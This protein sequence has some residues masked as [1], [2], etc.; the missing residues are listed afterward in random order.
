[1]PYGEPELVS[2]D[3]TVVGGGVAGT[4]AAVAAARQGADVVL[5][6]DRPVLGGNSSSEIRVSMCGATKTGHRSNRNRFAREGG[7][8]EEL[9][10]RTKYRNQAGN[11]H[12]WDATLKELVDAEPSLDLYLNTLVVD[13]AATDGTI[14]AATGHQDGSERSFRFESPVY[15]DATGNGTLAVAAGAESTVGSEPQ[16]AYGESM[17][18]ASGNDA[19]LGSTI[20]FT[21]RDAGEPVNYDPP[22]FAHDFKADTPPLIRSHLNG[23]T[24]GHRYAWWLEYGGTPEV[25]PLAD[26]EH[27]RDELW[28]IV[29]GLWDYIKNSGNFEDVETVALDWVGPIP[30]KR[31]SRRIVG[32]Y[33]TTEDDLIGS[34]RLPDRVGHGGWHIDLHPPAGI[35]D[36]EGVDTEGTTEADRVH[37]FFDGPYSYPYRSLYAP[38][39]TNL[40]L[41]GRHVSASRLA[42]ASLRVQM[43]LGTVG[44]AA[45]TAGALCARHGVT[46]HELYESRLEELQETLLREDQWILDRASADP[47]NLARSATVTA[48][49]IAAAERVTGDRAVPLDEPTGVHLP[50]VPGTESAA[51]LVEANAPTQLAVQVWQEA[52]PETYVPAEQVRRESIELDAGATWASVAMP[53][54]GPGH[55][56]FVVLEPNEAVSLHVSEEPLLGVLASREDRD[57]PLADSPWPLVEWTPCLRLSGAADLYAPANVIDGFARPFGTVHAWQSAP[58]VEDPD[59]WIELAWADPVELA[60]VQLAWDSTLTPWIDCLDPDRP[61]AMPSIVT[62]YRIEAAGADG[63]EPLVAET[64]NYQR[65]RRHAFDPVTT[66]GIRVIAEATHGSPAATLFEV[67][68]FGPDADVGG[69]RPV[70]LE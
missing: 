54:P 59:P 57:V 60:A 17:A 70:A 37:W 47:A 11:P 21:G 30:G 36:E 42:F 15:L 29:Y 25:D 12:L 48:S 20:M 68:A 52:R 44:Q 24:A 67:R 33:V 4:C 26:N 10:L 28:S 55:G 66:D 69:E 53:D 34:P 40:L 46:P 39:V 13:V 51:F 2:A 18:P 65:L 22:A 23:F 19:T 43:T 5:V 64:G 45:G 32:E 35:Y 58:L 56:A 9:A 6:N 38:A 62:D 61:S 1:M 41:A 16:S 8:V 63:W 31:E 27:V 14:T 50:L 49:S 3:L 7:I